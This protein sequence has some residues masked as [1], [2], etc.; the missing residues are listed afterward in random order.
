MSARSRKEVVE[1]ARQRYAIRGREGRSRLLGEVCELCG[2]QVCDQ[3][4]ERQASDWRQ[5]QARRFAG[6]GEAEREVIKSDLAGGRTTLQQALEGGAEGMAPA[7]REASRALGA[8]LRQ[9]ALAISASSIDRLLA[10]CRASL[11]GRARCGTRLGTLLRKQIPV[12]TE[13][14]DIS[15][16]GFIEADTV[17]HRGESMAGE[18]CWSLTATDVHTQWTETRAVSNRRAV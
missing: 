7:L 11:G 4:I 14:W 13:H 9:R 5:P 6:Y 18:F 3:G 10:P 16:P 2:A 15:T 17:A 8:G 1:Q 12:R